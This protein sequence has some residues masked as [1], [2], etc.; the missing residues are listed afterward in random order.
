MAKVANNI[1]KMK[2]IKSKLFSSKEDEY[3]YFRIFLKLN[4]LNNEVWDIQG[5]HNKVSRICGLE[6][7]SFLNQNIFWIYI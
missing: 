5:L 6:N 7:K 2:T 1:W 4:I 3:S